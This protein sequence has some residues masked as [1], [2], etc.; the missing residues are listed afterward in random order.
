MK[1]QDGTLSAVKGKTMSLR[2]P[3]TIRKVQPLMMR[4]DKHGDHDQSFNR[5]GNYTIVYPDG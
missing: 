1:N 2:V 5:F 4:M 3:A